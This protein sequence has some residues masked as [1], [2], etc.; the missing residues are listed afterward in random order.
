MI[1]CVIYHA[2][3]HRLDSGHFAV[4]DCLE[5]ISNNIVRFY[6]GRV[7]KGVIMAAKYNIANVLPQRMP[8]LIDS[9]YI[10]LIWVVPSYLCH[11]T[12][13]REFDTRD[14]TAVIRC[15]ERDGTCDI[16]SIAK[17]S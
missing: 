5:E 16:V 2:E 10:N 13:Y 6:E 17:S 9:S 1:I 12:I 15:K 14:K 11:T 4:E 7:A 8:S 3:L